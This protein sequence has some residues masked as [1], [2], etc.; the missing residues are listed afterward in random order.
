MNGSLMFRIRNNDLTMHHTPSEAELSG[1]C[2]DSLS[3]VGMFLTERWHIKNH[4]GLKTFLPAIVA[5]TFGNGW[6]PCKRT[7]RTS[8]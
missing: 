4:R 6:G 1:H 8:D 2:K 7:L 3:L 5:P